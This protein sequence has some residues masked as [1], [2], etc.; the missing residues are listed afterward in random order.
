M[1]LVEKEEAKVVK[2]WADSD[3]RDEADARNSIM[4][5]ELWRHEPDHH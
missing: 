2:F 3:L 4:P 1:S 5:R